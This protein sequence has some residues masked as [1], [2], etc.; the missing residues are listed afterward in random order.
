MKLLEKIA[1]ERAGYTKTERKIADSILNNRMEFAVSSVGSAAERLKVSKTS[2]VRFAKRMGFEGYQEFRKQLQEEEVKRASPSERFMLL[3]D[4]EQMSRVANLANLEVDNLQQCLGRLSEDTLHTLVETIVTARRVY[5]AGQ[6][7]ASFAAEIMSYRMKA[8]GFP[9]ETITLGRAGLDDQLIY[10]QKGDLLILFDFPD[11][12]P[13]ILEGAAYAKRRGL[14]I[15]LMTDDVTCPV[16]KYADWVLY[17]DAQTDLFKNS[18]TAP[19]FLI[20]VLMSL[21]IYR[22]KQRM[23]AFLQGQEEVRRLRRAGTE[24]RKDG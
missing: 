24:G 2:L 14:E 23:L 3:M 11:Y 15:A 10:A 8:L 18:L 22:D 12:S 6:S 21:A 19:V 7:M 20:N 16:V 13:P 17:C 5:T 9:F 1:Q 4:D